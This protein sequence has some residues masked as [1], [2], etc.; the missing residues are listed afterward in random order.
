MK[1]H[2]D[3]VDAWARGPGYWH[4]KKWIDQFN[5][6]NIESKDPTRHYKELQDKAGRDL[7]P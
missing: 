4:F 5:L 3:Q 2:E 1:A 7:N 6:G